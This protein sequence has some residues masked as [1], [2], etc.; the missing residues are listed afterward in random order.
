MSGPTGVQCIRVLTLLTNL[1]SHI[2]TLLHNVFPLGHQG[3]AVCGSP[4]CGRS[5]RGKSLRHAMGS[6]CGLPVRAV[7]RETAVPPKLQR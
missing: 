7:G 6:P 3:N 2:S 1:A 4:W 5:W